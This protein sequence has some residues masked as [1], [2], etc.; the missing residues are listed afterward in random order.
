MNKLSAFVKLDFIT[1]KPYMKISTLLIYTA[2]VASITYTSGTIFAGIGVGMMIGTL[3]ISYPFAVGEKSNMDA[4]YVTVAASRRTVVMGRYVFSLLVNVCAAVFAFL[5]QFVENLIVPGMV[6]SVDV[7][8]AFVGFAIL[9][10]I[11]VMIQAIQIPIFFKLGYTKAKIISLVPFAFVMAA[12]M[13]FAGIAA[14]LAENPHPALIW[15]ESNAPAICA[16]SCLALALLICASYRL[17]LAFYRNR[18]F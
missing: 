14:E 8:S 4:L 3:S 10:A 17:S 6:L 7:D 9:A 13:G 5:I 15:A 11:F 16:L 18:D 12:G 1:M 2:V